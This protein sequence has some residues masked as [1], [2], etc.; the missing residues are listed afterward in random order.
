V[1]VEVAHDVDLSS[2][3]PS[4]EIP[5][6]YKVYTNGKEQVSG[7]SQVDFTKPVTYELRNKDNQ[8][9][10][11]TV[12]TL[13]LSCK[14][15]IDA[16]HD[17]GIWWFPQYEAT[18]FNPNAP[19]QGQGFANHLREKGFEVT[20]LGRGIELTDEMFFGNYIIIRAGGFGTYTQKELEVYGRLIDRGT[21]LVY[22]TD[23]TLNDP[24]D[25]LGEHLG[26]QMTGAVSGGI[27][28][29]AP[30]EITAN[31]EYIDYIAGSVVTNVIQ[32]PNIEVLGWLNDGGYTDLNGNNIKDPNEPA[33]SPVMGILKYPKSRIFFIGDTNG[34]QVRPQPFIDNLIQWMG[35]CFVD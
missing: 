23:H 17:G 25:E 6:G 10:S 11:W 12:S 21:N 27:D 29:F 32:N 7:S 9:T 34:L 31:L 1:K 3:T 22:F 24:V 20:E 2:L 35:H 15:L 26:L 4:F 19:H 13:P 18:G 30:H 33:G 5:S 16:S 28:K 14:I 8:S